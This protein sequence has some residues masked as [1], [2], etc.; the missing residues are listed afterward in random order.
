MADNKAHREDIITT[1]GE[2]L[3]DLRRERGMT[4]AELA[5]LLGISKSTVQNYE[6]DNY[7]DLSFSMIKSIADLFDVS[8]DYLAGLKVNRERQDT[9]MEA[10]MLT[11][12]AVSALKQNNFDHLL[13]SDLIAHK[14]FQRLM[15]DIAVYA[16]Q[17]ASLSMVQNNAT[18]FY[19]R[20]LSVSP[21]AIRKASNHAPLI[22]Q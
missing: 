10:L 13:L 4:Q 11:D 6:T 14:G 20:E 19:A 9:P 15:L 22:S 12:E 5:D 1:F 17:A 18:L 8:I 3:E 16:S 2:R 21:Q 7:K